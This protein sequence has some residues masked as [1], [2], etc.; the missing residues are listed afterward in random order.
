M[1]EEVEI[2]LGEY[3]KLSDSEDYEVYDERSGQWTTFA[4]S[5]YSATEFPHANQA[6][7]PINVVTVYDT[8]EHRFITW[9][10]GKFNKQ[11][12]HS[13]LEEQ[14]V[15]AIDPSKLIYRQCK[16]EIELLQQFTAYWREN[17]PDV[18]SGWNINQFDIPYLTNRIVKLFGEN[19]HLVLSPVGRIWTKPII[20]MFKAPAVQ[21]QIAGISIVDYMELYKS[22]SRSDSDSYKLGDVASKELKITKIAH[23]LGDLVTLADKDWDLFVCYNIQDVNLLL[24][25]EQELNF[26]GI[27]RFVS[28]NGFTKVENALGKVTIVQGAIASQALVMGKILPTFR[29]NQTVRGEYAGGYVREPVR[30]MHGNIVS[31]DANSLYPNAIITLNISPECKVG[32]IL[33]KPGQ[34]NTLSEPVDVYTI[35]SP[36]GKI[37]K[38]P[39]AEFDSLV[40]TG[41]CTITAADVL[42]SQKKRGIIPNFID[43]LYRQRVEMQ[44]QMAAV[45]DVISKMKADDPRLIELKQKNKQ[46]DNIQYSTKILLNSIYG[47]FANMNS[48]LFD[49]DAAASI[50]LSG[51]EVVKQAAEICNLW[52]RAKFNNPKADIVRYGD[53]DSVYF[54]LD[55]CIELFDGKG[56]LTASGQS[57]IEELDGVI[58]D[59]ITHWA[60]ENFKTSDSRFVFKRE[61]LCEAG[62]FFDKKKRYILHVN[63]KGSTLNEKKDRLKYTGVEL[64]RSTYSD[65][66]KKLIK[67]VVTKAFETRNQEVTKQFY[68]KQLRAFME[69]DIDD[70]ALRT[71]IGTLDKYAAA[72]NGLQLASKTSPAVG[73]AITHNYLIDK[74]N[75]QAVYPKLTQ[76]NKVKYVYVE[77]NPY[78]VDGISYGERFPK[79]LKLVPDKTMMFE[80]VVRNS[81][82]RIFAAIDWELPNSKFAPIDTLFEAFG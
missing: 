41:Q 9:G 36:A 32:K 8:L 68:Y 46:L 24:L 6:N 52:A 74:F 81:L 11:R 82:S 5:S 33:S 13:V 27:A 4:N 61:T 40:K 58:N 49:L 70:I 1:L 47:N 20:N 3:L 29:T 22:F 35:Q 50:T 57:V 77:R 45:E 72:S 16:D 7:H 17:Y 59:Q 65:A 48:C 71:S 53:T 67:A 60:I 73:G 64:V 42:Y 39:Q 63:Y 14:N 25:L 15:P 28:V 54:S 26:L 19:Q 51:Q 21:T 30:G 78:G 66:A 56:I 23:G 38:L 55:G 79:E 12:L 80:K 69:L 76:G 44:T 34:E 62:V 2:T 43:G 10:I 37:V 31:Y 75:L 18:V